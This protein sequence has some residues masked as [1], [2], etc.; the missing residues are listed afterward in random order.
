VKPAEHVTLQ[1]L[2]THVEVETPAEAVW[3]FVVQVPQ[4]D[5]LFVRSVSQ[6]FEETPS[7][8]P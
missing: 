3:Q 4:A 1:T 2:L 7:Q 8:S 5:A 6:P